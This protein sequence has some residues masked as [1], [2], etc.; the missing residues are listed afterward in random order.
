T[1]LNGTAQPLP[2]HAARISAAVEGRVVSVLVGADGKP[3]HEGEI[4]HAGDVVVQLDSRIAQANRDRAEAAQKEL[5]EQKKQAGYA[6]RRAELE[7]QRL[8]NL[9]DRGS[10]SAADSSL[11]L[12]APVDVERAQIALQEAQAG[13]RA[14][15]AKQE[16]AARDLKALDAQLGLYALRAPITGHLGMLQVLPGQTLSVGAPVADVTDLD[17]ID[18]LCFA[19]PD[20]AARL[21]TGQP[22]QVLRQTDKGEEAVPGLVGK[23]VFLA[24]QGQPET[25]NFAVKIR[26]PNPKLQLR[27][28]TLALV[29]VM[30]EPEKERLTVPEA[31]LME[32]TSPPSVVVV[33]GLETKKDK[34]GK[35]QKVG[36]ARVLRATVG[37]R[38]REWHV[39]ELLGLEDPEKKQ[40]VA[41]DDVLVVTSGGHGL[42][43]GDPVRLAEEDEDEK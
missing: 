23:V 20:A 35:E 36:K 9:R 39:V 6:V 13:V 19:P 7:L 34:E 12:V 15:A 11:P 38:N 40:P 14:A 31:A 43:D 21:T 30:T 29:Q 2:Q 28:N 27:G 8:E 3:V 33:V 24:V 4:V 22:A 42:R 26:F 41:L 5:E 17:Q 1:P 37:V 18:V 32:D 16:T 10:A 25:G